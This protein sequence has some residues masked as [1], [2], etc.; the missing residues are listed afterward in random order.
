MFEQ[1]N[2]TFFQMIS[3]FREGDYSAYKSTMVD[4]WINN[5]TYDN[6]FKAWL[7]SVT[8][9][10]CTVDTTRPPS[11]IEPLNLEDVQGA[12]QVGKNACFSGATREDNTLLAG[13][14][15]CLTDATNNGFVS[16]GIFVKSGIVA[17]MQITLRNGSGNA[18]M[19]H[20][21]GEHPTD[22]SF[23]NSAAA[24]TG[25]DETMLVKN[26]KSGWNYIRVLAKPSFSNVTMLARYLE[27]TGG[28]GSNVVPTAN[29]N[30]PYSAAVNTGI[31]FSSNGSVD[32]DGSIA[33]YSWNF[34]DGSVVSTSANP[35]HSYTIAG[36]FTATLTVTDND[37]AT[38]S[39]SA[40]VTVTGGSNAGYCSVTGGGTHEWIAGVAVGDLNNAS[41]QDNYKLY[42]LTANLASG[43]N[44]ITLTPG[45]TGNYTE[46]WGVWI[47]YN[48]DGDFT[49][50]GEQVISGLSGT[51]A[52]TGSFTPPASAAGKTT[53][54]RIGMKY[55]QA[56]TAPCSNIASGEFEDY[57]VTIGGSEPVNKAPVA[58]T[59]G[60]F[61]G[62]VGFGVAMSSNNSSDSD[63]TI[64]NRAWNFGDGSAISTSTN[65]N[66][67]YTSA[68]TFT[69]TLT[70]TDNDGATHSVT[71]T[72]TIS[73]ANTGG[74]IVNACSIEGPTRG[75][76]LTNGDAICVPA[77]TSNTGTQ[78]YY[79]LVP[80][81]TNSISI[82]T[83]HGTGNG[84]LYYNASTW[85]TP[86][87]N[88]QSSAGPTNNESITVNNPAVGYRFISVVGAR[89]GSTLLVEL[90]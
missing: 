3:K 83:A 27:T 46:H 2:A 64:T 19:Q 51:S 29:A 40:A 69:I 21:A 47:D 42:N 38:A 79:I 70:V 65:P 20:K 30:G 71:T 54:M 37:G 78:S 15:V 33:S 44:T 68:G 75:G 77:S 87:A 82:R 66:H 72:A 86:T 84:D 57:T 50:T 62:T 1:Q 5:K 28:G 7:P 12:D 53:R 10:G 17:D 26:V 90:N 13:E 24:V 16:L 52:V 49:D 56:V 36:N 22:T 39:S 8:S 89:S 35:N 76:S 31:T 6:G 48:S 55:G 73:A 14:A 32:S 23:D 88:T 25:A 60:P 63:G 9:S 61:S 41:A 74:S 80:A 43:A 81:N 4:S 34:G 58:A 18:D 11:P 59:S 67:T 45:T 85:A